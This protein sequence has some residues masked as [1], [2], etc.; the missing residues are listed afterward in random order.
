MY[1]VDTLRKHDWDAAQVEIMRLQTQGK[2]IFYQPY[3]PKDKD[4]RKRPFI[5]V[6]QDD[7]MR[8]VGRRFSHGNSWAL[9]STFKT[10]HYDLPLYAAVVPNQDGKGVPV[11][12]MLCTK[13]KKQGHQG[14]ALE[15][16]LIAVF[17]SL[18]AV[19][20]SA[21]V[22]DKDKTSLNSINTVV[23]SDEHCWSIENGEK[24]Q[25]AGKVLLCHFHV[26][27]AWSENLLTRVPIPE[28]NK[29]WIALHVLMHC[30]KEEHF[31]ENLKKLYEDF[32]HIPSVA[33]YMEAGWAGRRVQWRNLW[34]RFGRLFAYGGMDTTNHI[35]RHWEWIKYSLLQAKVNRA[36]RDLIIAIVGSAEDGSRIGGPTLV[37]HFQMVQ[38]ISKFF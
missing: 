15:L 25:V 9:D 1:C 8:D 27:K 28:K 34:P 30:S 22:I 31:E 35:E 37:D 38:L 10:N 36:L 26:M 29:L 14:I 20:P 2:I 17:A 24:V 21:I 4:V 5:V 23:R 3:A 13:D 32:Q 33:E 18:G 7:W 19:R 16:A 11:F 6:I 12:Y